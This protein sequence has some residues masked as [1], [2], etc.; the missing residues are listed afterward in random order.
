MGVSQNNFPERLVAELANTFNR[1]VEYDPR[2]ILDIAVFPNTG[3]IGLKNSASGKL[4]FTAGNTQHD[5]IQGVYYERIDTEGDVTYG[6]LETPLTEDTLNT[7]IEGL[8]QGVSAVERGLDTADPHN[9]PPRPGR[10]MYAPLE[11]C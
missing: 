11:V 10:R 7:L 2:K 5:D 3:D 1:R 9:V 6:V 8:F 4:I